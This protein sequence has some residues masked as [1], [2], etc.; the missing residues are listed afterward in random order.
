MIMEKDLSINVDKEILSGAPVF[1]GTRAF[2][3]RLYSIIL[4]LAF[5]STNF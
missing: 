2:P 3:L 5:R 4:K 1:T